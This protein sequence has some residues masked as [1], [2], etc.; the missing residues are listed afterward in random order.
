MISRQQAMSSFRNIFS[1]GGDH[2]PPRSSLTDNNELSWE[3]FDR[4][5]ALAPNITGKV[6]CQGVGVQFD[7]QGGDNAFALGGG[8]CNQV[9]RQGGRGQFDL[10]GG[11]NALTL[12]G[13]GMLGHQGGRVQF[14]T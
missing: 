1:L 5:N 3:K 8:G 7:L 9:G 4:D 6:G 2:P 11:D 10:Q 12:G 13:G 14:D